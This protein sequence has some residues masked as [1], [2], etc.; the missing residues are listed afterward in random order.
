MKA[1]LQCHIINYNKQN[2]HCV[3]K[4]G[5]MKN[6]IF[7]YLLYFQALIRIGCTGFISNSL[8]LN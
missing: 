3:N 8:I 7:L 5:F 4:K 6:E 1:S 2:V